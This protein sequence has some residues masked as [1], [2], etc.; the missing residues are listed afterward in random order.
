MEHRLGEHTP[1][2]EIIHTHSG[3]TNS[4]IEAI[5]NYYKESNH[6]IATTGNFTK[7]NQDFSIRKSEVVWMTEDFNKQFGT[8]DIISKIYSK[9]DELNKS[10]FKFN[11]FDVEPLQITRYDSS[12]RGFYEMHTD[13]G[14]TQG[15]LVRKLSFVIQLSDPSEF[16][17]GEFVYNN[18][19][20][21]VVN[22]TCPQAVQKGMI[23]LFPS[24]LIHGVKPVTKG[25]RY[26][27]VGWCNGE[28]FK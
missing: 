1:F 16:E 27:L 21:T 20:E 19:V 26:S 2:L 22:E 12:N 18:G 6:E 3:L 10:F 5:K 24:F 23:I 7:E 8:F 11:L 4:E 25:T 15:N 13:A 9:V 17:G 28:R 14:F